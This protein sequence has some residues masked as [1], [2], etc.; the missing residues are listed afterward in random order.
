MIVVEFVV[1]QEA[2]F[3]GILCQR[4]NDENFEGIA[5]FLLRAPLQRL[6]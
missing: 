5:S 6:M 2:I 1:H 3:A 4:T